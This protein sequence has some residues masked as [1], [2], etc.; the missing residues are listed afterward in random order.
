MEPGTLQCGQL[1]PHVQ[2]SAKEPL[3][4]VALKE[5]RDRVAAVLRRMDFHDP[6]VIEEA[7]Q[8]VACRLDHLLAKYD[9]SKGTLDHYLYRCIRL[10]AFEG[11]R[12]EHGPVLKKRKVE[13]LGDSADIS[14]ERLG[15]PSDS[16]EIEEL[17]ELVLTWIKEL[18]ECEREAVTLWFLC[19]AK[20]P[21]SP[22]VAAR[23]RTNRCRGLKKLR[24]RAEAWLR[25]L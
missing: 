15:L 4:R 13:R 5:L 23:H 19:P 18:P 2:P 9:S 11:F 24:T 10:V 17:F 22:E 1:F 16:V 14:L 25:S 20:S 8:R 7:T 21:E 6:N 12:F 3:Q